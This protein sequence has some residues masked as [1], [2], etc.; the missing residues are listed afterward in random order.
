MNIRAMHAFYLL[1]CILPISLDGAIVIKGNTDGSTSFTFA[2]GPYARSAS[3]GTFFI[4]SL[5]AGVAGDFALARTFD[6]VTCFDSFA[7]EVATINCMEIANPLYNAAISQLTLYPAQVGMGGGTRTMYLPIAVSQDRPADVFVVTDK[8]NANVCMLALSDIKDATSTGGQTTRGIIGLEPFVTNKGATESIFL[9]VKPHDSDDFGQPNS[10]IAVT[11]FVTMEVDGQ[12]RTVLVQINADPDSALP[13]TDALASPL[14]IASDSL[15][16]GTDLASITNT[17]DMYFS[18]K[19]QRLYVGLQ[20]TGGPNAADGARAIALGRLEDQ[21]LTFSKLAPDAVFT[22]MDKIVGGTGAN[23]QI[24]VH[25]VR[26]MYTSTFLDYAIVLGNNGAPDSTQQSVFALPLVDTIITGSIN[27]QIQGTLANVLVPPVDV[28]TPPQNACDAVPQV[29]KGRVFP[30]AAT[31]PDQVY[32]AASIQAHIGAGPLPA[33]NITDI[34]VAHDAVFVSVAD[35]IGDQKPGLFYSQ[36]LFSADG[37]I[38]SWTPWQRVGGTTDKAFGLSYE[39]ELGNFL[40]LTGQT[41]QSVKTVKRTQWGFGSTDGLAS[42]VDVVSEL[43]PFASGGVQGFFDLPANTPGLFDISLLIATGFGKVALVESGHV[44]NGVVC[45]NTGDFKTDEQVFTDGQITET[46][47]VGAVR[48]VSISGGAL[49]NIGPIIASTIGVNG[50]TQQGYLFAGGAYGLAVLAQE[51]GAGW[52][53][54][55]GLGQQFNGLV[56]GMRFITIGDYCFVRKLLFDEGF[57]YVLTDTR[58]VRIDLAASDFSTGSLAV[59]TVATLDDIGNEP[60]GTLLDVVISNKFAVLAT[61]TGLYRVGNDA[62]IQTAVDNQ[63]VDWTCV[64]I[65]EGVPVVQF[66]QTIASTLE[67]NGW[68]K[69]ATGNLYIDDAYRGFNWAQINRYTVASVVGGSV[70]SSTLEPL[71]DIHIKGILTAFKTFRNFRSIILYDGADLFSS[72]DQVRNQPLG[73]FNRNIRVPLCFDEG[74]IISA[75]VRD[76]AS[77]AWI[78]AG[79]FGLRINE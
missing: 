40:W 58:L 5:D 49:A 45:P 18:T 50:I 76:S 4:G 28:F 25:T 38:A 19:L 30:E 75:I 36:A 55:T 77:G 14:D 42:L 1:L 52:S 79:D 44:E 62:N 34:N 78:V 21:K 29:F 20:V 15:K 2:V 24:S 69:S 61:S 72:R 32:T 37:T 54:L 9:A 57:L 33:G 23:A 7:P 56:D 60:G 67:P 43:F 17:I 64:V 73:L 27:E 51:N 12:P 47:P 66:L 16:I 26:T 39:S 46:F 65:P 11:P 10:G 31:S 71:P 59:T 74:S 6:G 68:A 22:G 8:V 70:T 53:T 41:S 48:V 13:A 35:A 63:A 3:G